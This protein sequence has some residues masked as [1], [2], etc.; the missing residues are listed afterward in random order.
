MS[1]NL[2]DWIELSPDYSIVEIAVPKKWIGRTLKELDIRKTYGVN[3][4][5]IKE[6]SQVEI[7][8][9]PDMPLKPGIILMLIGSNEALEK[10]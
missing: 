6:G 3:V 5:G 1:A 9:D 4:A 10:I 8:P 7:T 2:A